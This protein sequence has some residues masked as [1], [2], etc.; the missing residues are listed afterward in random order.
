MSH[1]A[2]GTHLAVESAIG[3][4][5]G[6]IVLHQTPAL[7]QIRGIPIV[8]RAGAA[9]QR[10]APRVPAPVSQTGAP[11]MFTGLDHRARLHWFLCLPRP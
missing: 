8:V 7:V 3:V 9:A 10:D 5:L 6:L 11:H 1:T 2:F 4:L